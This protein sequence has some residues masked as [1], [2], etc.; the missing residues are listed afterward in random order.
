VPEQPEK[1]HRCGQCGAI[2]DEPVVREARSNPPARG[3]ARMLYEIGLEADQ[4]RDADGDDE[5]VT[6]GGR[7]DPDVVLWQAE[8]KFKCTLYLLQDGPHEVTEEDIELARR[9]LEAAEE[10]VDEVERWLNSGG[11]PRGR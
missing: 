11:E 5:F 6:D 2:F 4:E 7:D 9:G 8:D 10:A 1:D 3:I